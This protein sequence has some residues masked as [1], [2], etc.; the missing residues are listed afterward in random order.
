[1]S[2]NGN[3]STGTSGRLTFLDWTRGFAILI[4]LQGHVFHS[5]SKSAL[6]NDGPYVISQFFGG[7]APAMFL[8]LTGITLAFIM[9]RGERQRL[10]PRERW[11]AAL[12]RSRYLFVIAFLFRLQLCVFGFPTS[13]T[14]ELLKV[15]VLN[16]MGFAFLLLSP[17]AFL[18][19]A[20]RA[21]AG[22][23]IGAAIAA[24]APLVSMIDWSW[25]HPR[26]SAYIIP[27]YVSFGFFPWAS[28]IAFGVGLGSIL[29]LTKAE[30]LNRVMQWVAVAGFALFLAG[31]YCSKF[32]YSLYPRSEF[33]LNSPWMVAMKLGP[34]L[35]LIAVAY[36]WTEYGS[37]GWS[38]LRQFGMTSLL[39]YWVHVELVYGRWF[40]FLH[41]R[42]NAAQCTFCAVIL[43]VLMLGLSRLRTA[44]KERGFNPQF[45]QVERFLPLAAR[46]RKQ[47]ASL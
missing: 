29:R 38:P 10:S 23:I 12:R 43:I 31:D 4:I 6:H 5:F 15:D 26:I 20:A 45:S 17:L 14:P 40:W 2:Q 24:G 37:K 7:V 18:T 25:L 36:L 8:L 19:T 32:S 46:A 16:C 33:W 34:V 11:Y 1:M 39:V 35:L 47:A 22:V 3:L 42:L 30:Q 9:D 27:S 21:R 28:F 41:D 13:P 44:L